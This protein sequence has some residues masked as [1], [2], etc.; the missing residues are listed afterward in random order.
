MDGVPTLDG[1]GLC[2]LALTWI[3]PTPGFNMNTQHIYTCRGSSI[4]N[5][6]DQQSMESIDHTLSYMSIG[7]EACGVNWILQSIPYISSK[8]WNQGTKNP[9]IGLVIQGVE[10]KVTEYFFFLCVG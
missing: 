5:R 1:Y 4:R 2:S 10:E 7:D 6:V 3:I 9:D 8:K